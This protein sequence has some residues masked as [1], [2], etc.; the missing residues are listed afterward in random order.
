[1]Y[2]VFVVGGGEG[3]SLLLGQLHDRNVHISTSI[4]PNK[5][6]ALGDRASLSC[7]CRREYVLT[8]DVSQVFPLSL[9]W[10]LYVVSGVTA[11]RYLNVPMYR[12]SLHSCSRIPVW[13]SPFDPRTRSKRSP[14]RDTIPIFRLCSSQAHGLQES[15]EAKKHVDGRPF[16]L[17]NER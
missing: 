8:Y 6:K 11:L 16:F 13:V 9:A 17:Q 2:C 15:W 14:L 10:W 4:T 12:Y 7:H 3:G 1:M 5:G